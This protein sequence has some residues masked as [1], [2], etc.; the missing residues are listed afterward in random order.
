MSSEPKDDELTHPFPVRLKLTQNAA[1]EAL[2]RSRSLGDEAL[3]KSGV[4][5]ALIDL[6]LEV[7]AKRKRLVAVV[8]KARGP[9]RTK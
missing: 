4:M 9:R 1:I 3:S 5:R 7:V 8:E 6:G 2:R